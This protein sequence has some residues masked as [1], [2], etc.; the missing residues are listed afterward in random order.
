MELRQLTYFTTLAE[1]LNF[2]RAAERLNMSQPP[3]TVAI[4]KLE[5]E[6]GAVLFLRGPRGVSL[7]TAGEAALEH[8]HAVLMEAALL[9]QAV[10]D[11][12]DG[13]RGHLS[14]GFVG[15]A[16]YALLPRLIRLYGKRYPKVEVELIESTSVEIVEQIQ[17]R[18]LDVGLV[19][20]PLLNTRNLDIDVVEQDELVVVVPSTSRLAD[21]VT[22]SLSE[23]RD[24]PFILYTDA[25][26]L[27]RIIMMACHRANFVPRL[28]QVASQVYTILSLVQSGLGIAMVPS[29]ATRHIPDGVTLLRLAEQQP[30]EAGIIVSSRW[31]TSLAR[32]FVTVATSEA[33]PE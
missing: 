21:R 12:A 1:T 15:S 31:A 7:T 14:I 6:L 28:A 26:A 11:E 2:R 25:S 22:V 20:L 17:S 16:I 9:R 24:E 23:L 30:I 5:A 3:L 19:R 8:A 4:R 13:E 18:R 27:R 32:N 29:R 10:G 33:G